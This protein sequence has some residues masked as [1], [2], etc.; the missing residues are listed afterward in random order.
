MSNIFCY[1]CGCKNSYVN[2]KKPKFCSSCGES[3]SSESE[4]VKKSNNFSNYQRPRK[5]KE[6]SLKNIEFDDYY[7]DVEELTLDF[8][9][10]TKQKRINNAKPLRNTSN[11]VF[12]VEVENFSQEKLGS[13]VN[14]QYIGD[15][16]LYRGNKSFNKN[17]I[18]DIARENQSSK[19]RLL[20]ELD[21]LSD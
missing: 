15:P 12:H 17:I 3:L 5:E 19:Q 10:V 9:D 2:G 14:S 4:S 1:N 16:S 11:D 13:I 8:S 7:E 18:Q 20:R 21:D 6:Q